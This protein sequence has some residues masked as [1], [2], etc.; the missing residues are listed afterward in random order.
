MLKHQILDQITTEK[1][2]FVLLAAIRQISTCIL[3]NK[4]FVKC[5][6]KF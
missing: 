2:N 1:F 6:D 5:C 4:C 3:K